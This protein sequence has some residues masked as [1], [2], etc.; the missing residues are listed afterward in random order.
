V[1]KLESKSEKWTPYGDAFAHNLVFG[2]T[3]V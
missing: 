3:G 2:K 1:A